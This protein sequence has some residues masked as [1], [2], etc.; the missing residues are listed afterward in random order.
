[1]VVQDIENLLDLL[2]EAAGFKDLIK[3]VLIRSYPIFPVKD[4]GIRQWSLL[5]STVC[6][7]IGGH[8]AQAS[9]ACAAI[10]LLMA[11]GEIFDDIEDVDS[12][13][14]LSVRYGATVATNVATT[15]LI[16]AEKAI[17]QLKGKGVADHIIVRVMDTINLYYAK[18]CAGQHLDLTLTPEIAN[19]EDIYF[20]VVNM[21][22]ASTP[23]CACYIGALLA[24]E[25]QELIDKF[26]LF[27]QNLG[28]ASQ[29]AND[30]LGITRGSDIVKRKMSLPII[31]TLNQT[32]GDVRSQVE[33]A[34]KNKYESSP[35]PKYIKD[36]LF[37]NGA[38]YYSTIKMSLYKQ[39]ALDI[40]SEVESKGANVGK[41]KSFLD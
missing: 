7:S 6:E 10:Q 18:A 41:L 39:R 16:L 2:S 3:G 33:L 20:K 37:N 22:S 36:L 21:K 5:P 35:D 25:N 31:Y 38:I 9:P 29:I 32:D 40:L 17:T 4:I 24:T 26:S 12:S 15:L 19:S 27:G 28:I 14:S 13:E 8:S 11:A 23:E 30:I 34:Y 1:M